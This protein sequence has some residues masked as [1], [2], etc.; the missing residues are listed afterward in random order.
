M[1]WLADQVYGVIQDEPMADEV[2][3]SVSKKLKKAK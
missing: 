2:L 1:L 3:K